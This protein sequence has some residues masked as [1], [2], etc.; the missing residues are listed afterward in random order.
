MLQAMQLMILTLFMGCNVKLIVSQCDLTCEN[1]DDDIA[2]IVE[3]MD[4]LGMPSFADI[5]N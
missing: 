2:E 3:A 4:D 1:V 5:T